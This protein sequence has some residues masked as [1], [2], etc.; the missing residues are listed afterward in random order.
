MERQHRQ[1]GDPRPESKPQVVTFS[2]DYFVAMVQRLRR[3]YPEQ[4]I[5]IAILENNIAQRMVTGEIVA[6]T[7]SPALTLNGIAEY[8]RQH[9][10]TPVRFFST[11][12][13]APA[14]TRR[15]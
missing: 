7:P 4:W 14:R 12:L 11:E 2:D 8:Q 5:G 6:H 3:K 13:A 10:G 15:A 1:S 9:P